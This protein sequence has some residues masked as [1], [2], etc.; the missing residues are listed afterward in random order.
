[1]KKLFN[2]IKRWWYNRGKTYEPPVEKPQV[3][4]EPQKPEHKICES[5]Y[6]KAVKGTGM[7][8]QGKYDKGYPIGAVV[9][10]TA[11]Q[12]DTEQ[13]AKDS[14][15]WGI[16]EG[17]AFFVIGPTGVVYQNFPLT[18]WGHHAGSSSYPGIGS[19]LSNKLVGIEVACAG[20]VSS[21]G[22]S[23]FG[24]TFSSDRIRYSEKKANIQPGYYV[25]YTEAQEK[26]LVEL[27]VWMKKNNPDVFD[28]KYILGHDEIAPSRKNDPGAS[29]SMTMP[30]LRE[31]IK[32]LADN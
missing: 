15:S 30:E 25:K 22:K 20:M 19:G 11:G 6:P 14:L 12:C 29:L 17:Y 24:K 7:K 13:H 2:A 16:G 9:H 31:K 27:L 5:W 4:P 28:V 18:H 10:F 3:K 32:R 21:S 1:M 26:A 8:V 23:W